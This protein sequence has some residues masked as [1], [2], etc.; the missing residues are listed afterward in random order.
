MAGHDFLRGEGQGSDD[1]TEG[2]ERDHG[3]QWQFVK[4]ALGRPSGEA[5]VVVNRGRWVH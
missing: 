2:S 3:R 5:A 4:S 1:W